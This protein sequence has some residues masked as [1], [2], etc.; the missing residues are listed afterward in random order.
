MKARIWSIIAIV[1]IACGIGF[2]MVALIMKGFDF[3][4]FSTEG[5]EVTNEHVVEED[6]TKISIDTSTA[7][8]RFEVSAD[9]RFHC[10]GNYY[11]PVLYVI[12]DYLHHEFTDLFTFRNEQ[13]ACKYAHDNAD[14][15][16]RCVPDA[17][18]CSL[19]RTLSDRCSDI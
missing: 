18:A 3:T 16:E 19:C 5:D 8:V 6:F 2:C 17:I 7:D 1:L 12:G 11:V 10:I 15:K 13:I 9:R 4:K 14:Y